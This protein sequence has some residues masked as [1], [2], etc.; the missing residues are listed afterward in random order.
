[1]QLTNA[2]VSTEQASTEQV[3]TE[4]VPTEQVPTEQG[5]RFSLHCATGVDC[6]PGENRPMIKLN[7]R[8]DGSGDPWLM[9]V[10]LIVVWLMLIWLMLV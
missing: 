4:Q 3:L 9:A 8:I 10:W 6:T 5:T 7:L 1:V 2:R